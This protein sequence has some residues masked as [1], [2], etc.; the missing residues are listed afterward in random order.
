MSCSVHFRNIQ[1]ISSPFGH[2]TRERTGIIYNAFCTL[3]GGFRIGARHVTFLKGSLVYLHETMTGLTNPT[4]MPFSS[5]A[6]WLR[7][8]AMDHLRHGYFAVLKAGPIPQH[9]AFVMDGNRRHARS[10]G[11]DVLQGHVDG[12]VAL[13]KVRVQ[14]MSPAKTS[15]GRKH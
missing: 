6:N 3:N 15:Q 1:C 9:I 4:T 13:K 2:P 7:G 11:V 14:S 12:V 5:S 10:N 8:H